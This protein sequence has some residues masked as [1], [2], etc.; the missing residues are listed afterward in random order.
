MVS[1]GLRDERRAALEPAGAPRDR[2]ET[3]VSPQP[4]ER[5]EFQKE[6]Q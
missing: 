2:G 1:R 6:E 4:D 3:I 5:K